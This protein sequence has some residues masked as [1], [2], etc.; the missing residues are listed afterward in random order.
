MSAHF[1]VLLA[2]GEVTECRKA[3]PLARHGWYIGVAGHVASGTRHSGFNVDIGLEHSRPSGSLGTANCTAAM[4]PG[5]SKS[6][7]ARLAALMGVWDAEYSHS[8]S[9]Q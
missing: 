8:T 9:Y 4:A 7:L 6:Q 1:R 5:A 3:G 2:L